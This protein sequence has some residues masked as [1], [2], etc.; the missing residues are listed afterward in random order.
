[1]ILRIILII[2][3]FIISLPIFGQIKNDRIRPAYIENGD[4]IFVEIL[5]EVEVYAPLVFD[6]KR[7]AK[8]YS[9]MV[10]YIK[11]V[12]PYAKIAGIKAR[13]YDAIIAKTD[14]ARNRRK[15]MRKAEKEMKEE[16]EEELKNLTY[17]Q[18]EILLKLIDRETNNSSYDLLKELRG[19]FKA[20]FYQGFAR[21]FGYNLKDRYD[22]LGRDKEIEQIVLLIEKG[23]I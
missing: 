23:K 8:R 4:T 13:E 22:P 3:I 5:Q 18:G 6:S 15:I 1:M 14:K 16:F 21:V 11:K 17:M 20:T 2:F 7:N 9:R 12:Y 10:W 19:G